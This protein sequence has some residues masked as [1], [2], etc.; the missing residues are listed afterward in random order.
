MRQ[1]KIWSIFF[2]KNLINK[3]I[4]AMFSITRMGEEVR[5]DVNQGVGEWENENLIYNWS[6]DSF[7]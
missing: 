2:I 5:E 4:V 3:E 1:G 7:I 6:K